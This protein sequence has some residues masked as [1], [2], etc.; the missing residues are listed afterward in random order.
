[1]ISGV[2]KGKLPKEV[3]CKLSPVLEEQAF[4]KVSGEPAK[5]VANSRSKRVFQE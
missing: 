3:L 2:G 1:M 5:A 4:E